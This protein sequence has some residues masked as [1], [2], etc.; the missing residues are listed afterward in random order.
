[1]IRDDYIKDKCGRLVAMLGGREEAMSYL[2]VNHLNKGPSADQ[3]S[4]RVLIE[5]LKDPY[6][7]I[8]INRL[9]DKIAKQ[10]KN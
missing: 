3:R 4:A 6:L 5:Y 2:E 10:N 8:K 9:V 7:T 1:M